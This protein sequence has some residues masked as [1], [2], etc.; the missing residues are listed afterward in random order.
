MRIHD[1]KTNDVSHCGECRGLEKVFSAAKKA[2][3]GHFH[4]G[5]FYNSVLEQRR[6][7]S[8]NINNGRV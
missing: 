2:D 4:I 1:I 8:S 6:D 3:P 5:S 7:C